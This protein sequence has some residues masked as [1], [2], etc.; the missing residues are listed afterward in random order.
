MAINL[1][2]TLTLDGRD[3]FWNS[4]NTGA[5]LDITHLQFGTRN[6]LPTGEES[7]LSL[8]KQSVKIQNGNKIGPDQVRIMA[9]M[10]GIENYNV[11][12]IGL[13]SGEPGLVGSILI[14]YTSVRTGYIAQM[15]NGIDLVFTYDMVIA[16]TDIDKINIVKDTDQSSTFSLLAEHE[17]DRNAHPFY[18]TTDTAQTISGAKTFTNKAIFSGG[19][20]GELTGNASTATQLKTPRTIGGVSF[21]GTANI[22]LPGVDIAGNQNTSGNAATASKLAAAVLIG[23]VA[24]DGSA[25]INLPG[26]NIAGNQ[27]TSGNAATATKLQTA[28]TIALSGAVTG[29]ATNFDGSENITI[30]TTS[31][32]GSK[33]NTGTIPAARIPTLNQNTTGSAKV[34]LNQD[35]VAALTGTA[36]PE[37]GLSM[38]QGYNNGYPHAYGNS[39]RLGGDG[40]GEIYVGWSGSNGGLAPSFIRNKRDTADANWSA[41]REIVFKDEIGTLS[42]ATATKLATARTIGGVS[43]DGTADINLPGVNTT[44]NQSTTGNAATATKLATA[45]SIN[46][47]SFDGTANITIAD[48]TK[49]P[50]TGGTLTGGLNVSDT[51]TVTG[52]GDHANA[53]KKLIQGHTTTDSGY[54]AVGNNG[55]NRGYVEIGTTD[56]ADEEIYATQRAS[57]DNT[58]IRRAKLLDSFGNTSFPGTVTAPAFNGT[59]NGNATSATKLQTAR[60]INGVSFDGTSDINIADN[61]KLP[62]TGGTLT[63]NLITK[64]SFLAQTIQELGSGDNTP[65][66]VPEITVPSDVNGYIPFIHASM[67][68]ANYGY[69]TQISI[70]GYRGSNTWDNSGAYIAI[71]GSDANPT[72]SFRF[73]HGRRI[74]NSTGPI[75]LEGNAATATKLAT[76]RSINGVGFDGTSNITI[77]AETPSIASINSDATLASATTPGLYSVAGYSIAGLYDYGLLRVWSFG[78]VWNQMFISHNSNSNGSVAIRQSWN[79]TAGYNAWRVI[80]SPNVGGNAATATKLQTAR[81]INGVSFDGSANITIADNTKLPLS[82]GT[83]TGSLNVSDTITVTNVG[84]Q[85]GAFKKL[86]QADTTTDGGYIAVGNH[87]SDRGYLELGTVDDGDA[88]IYARKRNGANT[89]LDEAVILGPDNNTSFPNSVFIHNAIGGYGK[90][91]LVAGAADDARYD[92]CNIDITSW[93]GLGI[94]SS[95]NGDRTVVFNTRNGDIS[96]KGSLHA[97]GMVNGKGLGI[98]NTAGTGA[99]LSLHGGTDGGMPNYGISFAQT[100]HHGRHGYVDGDWATYFTMEGAYNRGWIFKS[101]TH[102]NVASISSQGLLSI[103]TMKMDRSNFQVVTGSNYTVTY[104]YATRIVRIVMKVMSAVGVGH[105]TSPFKVVEGRWTATFA[106]PITLQ[107]RLS[108]EFAFQQVGLPG[109]KLWDAEAGEWH[110]WCAPPGHRGSTESAVT[111][112]VVRWRGGDGEPVD[113]YLTVVG[114]F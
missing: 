109:Y 57:I 29:T 58:V 107:V 10:P 51:I 104:D 15:V 19:L 14:A 99:G 73:L 42:A 38:V 7:L 35:N 67:Q 18:V 111:V 50:L 80:D 17:T 30:A 1:A 45:R 81:T 94:K 64:T 76:A 8:P 53:F 86:I 100:Q 74:T 101:H 9:T 62:L 55:D 77:A 75:L 87:G 110:T 69:R 98:N 108:A 31:I 65:I 20:T 2:L 28:R 32:D 52:V 63:G 48:N 106:L 92:G 90:C 11:T 70:G 113:G 84:E 95:Q 49:L 82:G 78:G 22:N 105:S 71:G 33:I 12:E 83:I 46:G 4:G 66:R 21:N 102:G 47:V 24:F 61:T 3:A 114:F 93:F 60:T 6:R 39:L 44:G 34:V 25:A 13:W 41:W 97:T 79:G 43:F 89:I 59:L 85:V 27:N 54:I 91:G 112:D 16:T 23:G 56:D 26:V 36:I 37:R 103:P 5:K 68:T 96:T 40:Q 88:A 72:E